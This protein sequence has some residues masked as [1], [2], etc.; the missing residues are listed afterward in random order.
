MNSEAAGVVLGPGNT[1]PTALTFPFTLVDQSITDA[2]GQTSSHLYT[3]TCMQPSFCGR[4]CK[5]DSFQCVYMT[6]ERKQKVIAVLKK[7]L[8]KVYYS[9]RSFKRGKDHL[10][11][12]TTG[13]KENDI[14]DAGNKQFRNREEKVERSKYN[15]ILINL[16]SK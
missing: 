11:T 6:G 5:H 8:M 14:N 15:L 4:T 3:R 7:N 1:F 10:C 16:H 2:C 12:L 13:S 9:S